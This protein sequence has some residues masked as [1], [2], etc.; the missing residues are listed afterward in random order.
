MQEPSDI[1]ASSR[2][3]AQFERP[4]KPFMK[5]LI[6]SLSIV[7]A[8]V[9]LTGCL[10]EDYIWW[11]PNGETAAIATSDGLRLAS[12]NG[13]LSAVVLPGEIQAAAW[14][15]DSSSLIVSRSLKFTN[16]A[17]IENLIPAQENA[18]ARQMAGAIPD[19]LKAGLTVTDGDAKALDDKF[20]KPLGIA[21]SQVLG[22]AWFCALD[23]YRRQIQG[24]MAGF[25]NSAAIEAELLSS[26]TNG[27]EV[28]EITVLPVREGQVCG[29][30]RALIHSLYPLAYPVVSP[31][32]PIVAF[33]AGKGRLQAL[34]IAGTNS[35]VVADEN[36]AA[37]AWSA[38][39][40]SLI[41]FVAKEKER[42]GEIRL[43][44]V[45]SAA[46]QLLAEPA[47]ADTLAIVAVL[48]ESRAR[49]AALPDG[50]VLFASVPLTLPA[51]PTSVNPSAQFF[52]L[53]PANTNS[54]PMAVEVKEG[55]LP[56]DL[57]AYSM[58][59][60]GRLVAVVEGGTDAVAVLELATGKV[61][62]I[63]PSH[64]GCKSR[65]IPAW[66]NG[67]ELVF[68]GVPS[69]T[70]ARPE[71]LLWQPGA[72]ARVLSAGWPDDVVKSWLEMSQK[73]GEPAPK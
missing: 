35:L 6:R 67:R 22:P 58:S 21:D 63:A 62:I 2:R 33:L 4:I 29:E 69:S 68:A 32:Y 50:R 11:S 61:R 7:G 37:A 59:P 57:S 56:D 55:S 13:Q 16:W 1:R 12:T 30:P 27:L 64:Q 8:G 70:A 14:L 24:V 40:R 17:A 26:E 31:R 39:G 45:V 42:I 60:D 20:L 38:D 73:E 23:L 65:L 53:D 51:R 28:Y 5:H 47:K 71:L 36:V 48:P 54:A 25:T 9:F 49:L 3:L 15:Y 66:R 41:H 19:L 44:T 34:T 10:P 72:A 43:R 46:G 18:T 52:L